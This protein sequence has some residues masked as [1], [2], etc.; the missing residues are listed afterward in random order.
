MN[1]FYEL[2]KTP[3][4]AADSSGCLFEMKSIQCQ[5]LKCNL[6]C[7]YSELIHDTEKLKLVCPDCSYTDFKVI[8]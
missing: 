1:I 5:N 4:S 6:I 2:T 3:I 8:K 7:T